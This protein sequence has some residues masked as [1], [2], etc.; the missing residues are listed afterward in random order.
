M[1]ANRDEN[2][3]I[4]LIGTSSDDGLTPRLLYANPTTHDALMEHGTSGSD[5]SDDIADRDENRI[6]VAM[7]ASSADGITPV[8]LYINSSNELLIKTT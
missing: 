4:T 5:L 6:P 1:Q 2:K 7:A 8:V 3:V